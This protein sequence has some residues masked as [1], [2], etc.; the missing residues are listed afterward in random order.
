MTIKCKACV[1]IVCSIAML[2]GFVELV[3]FFKELSIE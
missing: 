3:L 1:C 2:F